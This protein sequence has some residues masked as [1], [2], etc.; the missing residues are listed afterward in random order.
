[1]KLKLRPLAD[2]III[3]PRKEEEKTSGG[4]YLPDTMNKEKPMRG[5]VVAVGKGRSGDE[6]KKVP[7]EVKVNDEVIYSKYAGTE[8]KIEENDYLIIKE[9]DVLAI[10]G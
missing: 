4:V 3:E 9:D 7:M 1:M 6:G 10:L 8:V 5:T 2:R